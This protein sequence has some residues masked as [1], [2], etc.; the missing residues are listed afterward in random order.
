MARGRARRS[1]CRPCLRR[2]LGRIRPEQP[3]SLAAGLRAFG[4]LGFGL[5]L[6]G[7]GGRSSCSRISRHG[8]LGGGRL[9]AW[10]RS[11]SGV[12]DLLGPEIRRERVAI[13]F[14]AGCA[15]R[16]AELC[17]PPSPLARDVLHRRRCWRRSRPARHRDRRTDAAS[18]CSLRPWNP[19]SCAIFRSAL[20]ETL[21]AGLGVERLPAF[22]LRSR[23][24][25]GRRRYRPAPCG[26]NCGR[27]A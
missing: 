15:G 20:A 25:W 4:L 3:R 16:R 1:A 21:G 22:P 27:S 23:S 5:L 12:L 17:A 11:R 19:W 14:A 26:W 9:P 8:A 2:R 7:R 13:G 10:P 6:P 18:D 24:H